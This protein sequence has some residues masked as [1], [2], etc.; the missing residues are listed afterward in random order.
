MPS[1]PNSWGTVNRERGNETDA[2]NRNRPGKKDTVER[3]KHEMPVSY[4]HGASRKPKG[5]EEKHQ[6]SRKALAS[7]TTTNGCH[8]KLSALLPRASVLGCSQAIV[9][10]PSEPPISSVCFQVPTSLK[11]QVDRD[12][13]Q[14]PLVA[15]RNVWVTT[16][17]ASL[18]LFTSCRFLR[19]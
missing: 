2:A 16:W 3:L 18:V 5:K 15:V 14:P 8:T 13:A 6:K 11:P 17:A 19:L 1:A 9:H 4:G 10:P 12:S 7:Q